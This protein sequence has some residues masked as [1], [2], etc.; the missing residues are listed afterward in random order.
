VPFGALDDMFA[1]EVLGLLASVYADHSDYRQ[2]W[3][4]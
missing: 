2:E 1:P 4:A 3:A